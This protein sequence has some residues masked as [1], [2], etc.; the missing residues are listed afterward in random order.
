M[1]TGGGR[2]FWQ[3]D[4]DMSAVSWF[5]GGGSERVH[6]CRGKTGRRTHVLQAPDGG[7]GVPRCQRDLA[8]RGLLGV[9]R[10]CI[11]FRGLHAIGLR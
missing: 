9:R 7:S 4:K 10:G 6:A 3:K 2:G 11:G 8:K 5:G 1:G